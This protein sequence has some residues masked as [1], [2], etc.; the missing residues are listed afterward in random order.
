[1]KTLVVKNDDDAHIILE[2]RGGKYAGM[3]S[4]PGLHLVAPWKRV[5]RRLT[6]E[7]VQAITGLGVR[8]QDQTPVVVS[9]ALDF[10]ITDPAR[11]HQA[12]ADPC[13]DIKAGMRD[14][15]QTVVSRLGLAELWPQRDYVASRS[16][17]LAAMQLNDKFGIALGDVRV[18]EISLGSH[19]MSAPSD[20]LRA[21]LAQ[22]GAAPDKVAEAM[23]A[24]L[25]KPVTV[26]KPLR[27]RLR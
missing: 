7:P 18:Q 19:C 11:Y 20:V 23:D 9:I 14:A 22:A 4:E 3:I 27:L 6:K 15:A 1:M 21:I 5:A 25:E 12:G 10:R 26:S 8:A 24:G 13:E 2:T 16:Q 17:Q